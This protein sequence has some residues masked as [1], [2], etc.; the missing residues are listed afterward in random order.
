MLWICLSGSLISYPCWGGKTS[1]PDSCKVK[2]WV[3]A[4]TLA[5]YTHGML[6]DLHCVLTT[7]SRL[8]C[9]L[10]WKQK[11]RNCFLPSLFPQLPRENFLERRKGRFFP[12]LETLTVVSPLRVLLCSGR[13]RQNFGAQTQPLGMFLHGFLWGNRIAPATEGRVNF[14]WCQGIRSE[15]RLSIACLALFKPP[16]YT[17][18]A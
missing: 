11:R 8:L 1:R 9:R 14:S 15:S 12:H 13:I 2:L 16:Y 4:C 17:S 18:W 10:A 5:V 6:S 7:A 3:S